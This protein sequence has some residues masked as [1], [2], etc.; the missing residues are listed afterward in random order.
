MKINDIQVERPRTFNI[1]HK[2]D[3]LHVENIP[4]SEL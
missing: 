1:Y 4:V 2:I 3:Y